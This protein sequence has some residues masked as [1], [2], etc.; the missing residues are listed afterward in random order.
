MKAFMRSVIFTLSVFLI[1]TGCKDGK[2]DLSNDYNPETD[3]PYLFRQQ[4]SNLTIAPSSNGYYFLNE[5]YLYYA[6]KSTMKPVLLDNRPDSQ[7]LKESKEDLGKNCLAYINMIGEQSSFLAYY[8]GKIYTLQMKP[9]LE[10]DEKFVMKSEL[11]QLSN[12][13]TNRKSV[14]TFD[15]L[16]IALAIHRDRVYYVVQEYDK[17]SK[18]R[19]ELRS[20]TLSS[21]KSELIY[22]GVYSDGGIQDLFA[23]GKNLYF[24]E[25]GKNITK[26]MRYDIESK[27]V[28]PIFKDD[29]AIQST[30]EGIA[31]KRLLFS[32]FYGD[33][34]DEKAKVLYSSD[35][36]GNSVEKMPLNRDFLSNFYADGQHLYARPVWFYLTNDKYK[37]IPNTMTVYDSNGQT[38]GSIDVSAFPVDQ[39]LII[40]DDSF[41][42]MSYKSEGKHYIKY[43]KKASIGQGNPVFEPFIETPYQTE[44]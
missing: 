7:C 20:F 29:K 31:N 44:G 21:N 18:L 36:E 32:Y 2:M 8:K 25:H 42:F 38:A 19:Y 12:D 27:T 33:I 34:E 24:T 4:G 11:L 10:G 5:N 37:S 23:Y 1:L 3:F 13:G 16:P 6:D 9:S 22:K 43:L 17:N 30:L 26:T 28:S 40:G 35:L 41:M 14:F 15:T 39:S